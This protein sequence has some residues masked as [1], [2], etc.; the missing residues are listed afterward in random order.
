M[1]QSLIKKINGNVEIQVIF[2][3]RDK[4]SL[5]FGKNK[6]GLLIGPRD[7]PTLKPPKKKV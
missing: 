3:K 6:N 1:V 2:G 7:R 5:C 4:P